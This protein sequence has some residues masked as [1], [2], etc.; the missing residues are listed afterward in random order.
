MKLNIKQLQFIPNGMFQQINNLIAKDSEE[1]VDICYSRSEYG[2]D[3]YHINKEKTEL[4]I[5]PIVKYIS[6]D[7]EKGIDLWYSSKKKSQFGIK[8]VMF[9]IGSGVGGIA[10]DYN[11]EYGMCEFTAG[12]V[13]ETKEELEGIQKA[14]TSEKFKSI[15]NA[16]QFT[17]QMYNKNIISLF[18]K[19]FYK[20]FV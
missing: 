3:K 16:C 9:G 11:G 17:T 18:K 7:L 1:K 20:D 4:Y 6:K 8:K 19:D 10:I 12:I 2:H 5:Y 15:M 14:I 13:G